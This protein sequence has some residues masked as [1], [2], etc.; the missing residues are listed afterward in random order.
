[1]SECPI[2]LSDGSDC[3]LVCGHDAHETCLL[4]AIDHGQ[5]CCPKC[6]DPM[7]RPM[8]IRRAVRIFQTA[9]DMSF[10][11][12]RTRQRAPQVGGVQGGVQGGVP[13]PMPPCFFKRRPGEKAGG[14]AGGSACP[15]PH[16]P[17]RR[18]QC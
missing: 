13:P 16:A 4:T 14:S 3:T 5:L 6:R 12:F 1:M 17:P 8:V 15:P 11:D 7:T 9:N 18:P 10:S 2:C